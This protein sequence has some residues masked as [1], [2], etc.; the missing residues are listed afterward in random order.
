M[1]G[2]AG[3]GI[4][5]TAKRQYCREADGPA[6]VDAW[7]QSGKCLSEFA[8]EQGVHARRLRRWVAWLEPPERHGEVSFHPARLTDE[9]GAPAQLF[10]SC[11]K[12]P[13]APADNCTLACPSELRVHF[14]APSAVKWTRVTRLAV[15]CALHR[16]WRGQPYTRAIWPDECTV[17]ACSS[18]RPTNRDRG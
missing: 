18:C 1:A 12:I 9:S 14:A 11:T 3:A 10:K 4:P 5:R 6:L 15:P 16:V 7:R 13:R 17:I 8:R 2:D